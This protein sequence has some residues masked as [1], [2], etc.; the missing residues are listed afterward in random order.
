VGVLLTFC[1]EIGKSMG[2]TEL[3]TP[4][5]AIY[6]AYLGLTLGDIVSGT[7]SQLWKTRKKV[8]LV[9]HL[10]NCLFIAIYL[11]LGGTSLTVFYGICAG[12]GFS[13]GFW[14]VGVT[15][16]AEQFGTNVRS[17]VTATIPNFVRGTAIPLTMVFHFLAT[18]VGI[19]AS[20][21][22]EGLVVM[23]IAMAAL[24]NLRETYGID[25]DFIE[26]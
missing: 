3:P 1:P 8:I 20:A 24:R 25:L 12:L 14:A 21:A 18:Q 10:L 19:R 22:L 2:L 5:R 6:F 7:W 15:T 23:V 26:K 16:V 13:G 17:T 11:G 9:F 4:G